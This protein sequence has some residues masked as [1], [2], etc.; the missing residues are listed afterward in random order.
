MSD[1]Q[2]LTWSLND[3]YDSPTDPRL[4]DDMA[5]AKEVSRQFAKVFRGRV[6]DLPAADLRQAL[7][8]LEQ[9]MDVAYR[10][11]LYAS[12]AFAADTGN[13]TVQDLF[14][15]TRQNTTEV[16]NEVTFFDIE[17][18]ALFSHRSLEAETKSANLLK[19]V[20]L[21]NY[22]HYLTL[23]RQQAPHTLSE[24]E[25]RIA[26]LKNLTGRAAL[27]QLYTEVTS[28][29]KIPSRFRGKS[30]RLAL[31]RRVLYGQARTG[32]RVTVRSKVFWARSSNTATFSIFASTPFCKTIVWKP[33][34]AVSRALPN[35][36]LWPMSCPPKWSNG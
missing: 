14:N 1:T 22:S 12:L 7:V 24:G 16:F 27:D 29:M 13:E 26:E 34:C 9:L 23:L 32:I 4:A 6:S 15:R 8:H 35:R 36:L 19:S 28:R 20:E 33:R 21:K 10:P 18:K 3:L 31:P 17:L 11:Q 30:E 5:R 25:E 2:Q